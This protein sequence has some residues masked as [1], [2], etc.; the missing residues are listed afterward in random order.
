MPSVRM[1]SRPGCHL[2]DEARAVIL[3]VRERVPFEYDE[4]D[5]SGVDALEL[6]YGIR[7]PV[8]EVDGREWFEISV[9]P[10]ELVRA[11]SG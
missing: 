1:Y 6:E 8:V 3:G 5:I 11:L 4:V 10:S 7:I 9:T 2:C